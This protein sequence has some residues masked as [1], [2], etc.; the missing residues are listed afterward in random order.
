M[1][2]PECCLTASEGCN[3]RLSEKW[4]K[5][6]FCR[7][8]AGK[9]VYSQRCLGN[10]LTIR[11][12]SWQVEAP[13][14]LR[15]DHIFLFCYLALVIYVCVCV[16]VPV[17]TELLWGVERYAM[18][19]ITWRAGQYQAT[20]TNRV[21]GGKLQV[22][23]KLE[24]MYPLARITIVQDDLPPQRKGLYSHAAD[25]YEKLAAEAWCITIL[26]GVDYHDL[27]W[28][29]AAAAIWRLIWQE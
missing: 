15:R 18:N 5:W 6:I 1:F 27:F 29:R 22:R 14:R 8:P 7:I 11:K 2:C 23:P 28:C 17:W 26:P 25:L 12:T 19:H 10:T 3:S 13:Q 4:E 16:R 9:C 24:G 21:W 20:S